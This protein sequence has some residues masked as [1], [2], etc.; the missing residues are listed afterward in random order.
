MTTSNVIKA[1]LDHGWR[2]E[3]SF[4]RA[5]PML[6]NAPIEERFCTCCGEWKGED[7]YRDWGSICRECYNERSLDH[8]YGRRRN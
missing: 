7:Q 8:Y 6:T 5:L 2:E 1:L 3:Y 4:P